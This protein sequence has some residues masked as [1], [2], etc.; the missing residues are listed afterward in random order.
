MKIYLM[1]VSGI[2]PSDEKWYKYLSEKR[3]KKVKRLRK[4]SRKAQSIGAELLLRYAVN[5]ITGENG[6]VKWDTDE[7][8]KPYL[9]E[10]ADI[11]VNLSHS[12]DYAVCVL[13]SSPVGID[14]QRVGK[15]DMGI[16]KRFFTA[17]ETEYIEASADRESAFFEI[18]T[19]KES[20][21]KAVGKGIAMNMKE[22]SVLENEIV[23]EGERYILKKCLPKK[24]G[25]KISVCYLLPSEPS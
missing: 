6:L 3:I 25:Y 15:C 17:E 14:I 11:Y 1:N 13:H 10:H 18:W 22:F 4:E 20:F 21:T 2:D 19:K 23:Y 8:G 16:A 24:D 12:G 9:T 7:N 5:Q